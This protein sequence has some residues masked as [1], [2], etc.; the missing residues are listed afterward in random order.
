MRVMSTARKNKLLT[1]VSYL[2]SPIFI[3]N[4]YSAG[5]VFAHDVTVNIKGVITSATC[6]VSSDSINKSVYLGKYSKYFFTNT[7]RASPATSFIINL[8][9]CGS[10]TQDV[11]VAFSGTP[12]PDMAN[13]FKSTASGLAIKIMDDTKTLIPVGATSKSYSIANGATNYSI[14][15]YAQMVSTGPAVS[16]G[17]VSSS[18]TFLTTYP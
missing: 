11:A 6:S 2:V 8:E 10:A 12:D 16:S 9:N 15:F 14:Q 4:V 5:S 7:G 17:H 1:F 18:V 3:L 13:Y